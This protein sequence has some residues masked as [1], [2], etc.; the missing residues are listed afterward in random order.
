M[1][2]LEFLCKWAKGDRSTESRLKGMLCGFF[3]S[4]PRTIRNWISKTPDY[5]KWILKKID[6]EWE[7]L[8]DISYAIFFE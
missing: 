6:K 2:L 7:Q 3:N 1:T 5:V 8:G 4:D